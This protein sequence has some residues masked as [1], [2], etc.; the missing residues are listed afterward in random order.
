M[1]KPELLAPVGN[2]IMLRAAIDAGADAVYFGSKSLNMR[3]SANNFYL[4]EIKKVVEECHKSKLKA[5][6]TVNT[7]VYE[8]EL[9]FVKKTLEAAKTAGVDAVICWDFAVIEICKE[10]G[11]EVHLSTQVSVSNSKAAKFFMDLGIKR[12]VF[13]REV[14]LEDIKKIKEK[15]PEVEVE[16]FGHGAMCVALSGRCYMTHDAVGK[17]ANR[18]DCLQSC[19]REYKITDV[20][21]DFEFNMQTELGQTYIMSPKDLN[22]ISFLDRLC[23]YIDVL[24]I[25]GR[26]K[27]P[28]YVKEVISCYREAI[29]SVENGSYSREKTFEWNERL[30]KVH[31]RGFNSG[32]YLGKPVGDWTTDSYGSKA[33]L[34]KEFVGIVKN[35]YKKAGAAEVLLQARSIKVGENI[36]IQGNK[37]G[38]HEELIES[39]QFDNKSIEVGEQ[40]KS[41]ALKLSKPVR[42]N[43]KVYVTIPNLP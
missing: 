11:I 6:L 19:R 27:S 31:N 14:S 36:M 21:G 32:F 26:G 33:K 23:P 9:D 1:K 25:E 34:K 4:G 15:L 24:K 22:T 16:V 35:F 13:A 29:D 38:V 40:G 28:E 2:F 5:Y 8:H 7:I 37:T 18:G 41:V 30:T 12:I 17:S 39:I 3:G 10:L 42:A 20:E 43:D